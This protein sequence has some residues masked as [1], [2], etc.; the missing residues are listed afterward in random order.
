MPDAHLHRADQTGPDLHL[1]PD[2][3][4]APTSWG[5]RPGAAGSTG[6][7]LVLALAGLLFTTSIRQAQQVSPRTDSVDQAD[8]YASEQARVEAAQARVDELTAQLTELTETPVNADAAVA[9]LQAE[10]AALSGPAGF[11]AV[12]GPTY[13]VTLDDAPAGVAR[14]GLRPDEL[15]V[16]QQDVQAVVNA[17]WAGGAEAMTLMGRRVV[18][19]TAVRCVGNTLLLENRLYSPPYGI[20]AVGDPDALEAALEASPVVALYREYVRQ[21]GLGW[22]AGPGGVRVLPAYAGPSR[23]EHVGPD[24]PLAVEE[25]MSP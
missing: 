15:V 2:A 4:G 3:T 18:S 1:S 12:E 11:T 22:R 16:H 10:A 17:L 19:T 8:L 7:L 21:V 20:V 13:V 25:Q 23:L 9:G 24:P 5:R 14:D 6:L